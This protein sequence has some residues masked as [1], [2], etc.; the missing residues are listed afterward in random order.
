MEFSEKD[1]EEIIFNADKE[2]LAERGLYLQ[3]GKLFRQKRIGNYGIADLIHCKF[4][5]EGPWGGYLSISIIELKKDKIG[6]SAFLQALGYAKGIQNWMVKYRPNIKH[7]LSIDLVGKELDLSGNFCYL[8]DLFNFELTE[9]CSINF[10]TYSYEL[11]GLYF[12]Q[13]YD[14]KLNNEGF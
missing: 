6:I 2:E 9:Y 5:H 12:N 3:G 1:L 13:E 14:F 10:F 11:D 7:R 8:T 4:D